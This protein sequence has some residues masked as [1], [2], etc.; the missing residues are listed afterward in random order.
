MLG[1]TD[2]FDQEECY[3][4]CTVAATRAQSLTIIISQFDM[5]GMMGMMQVL[6]AR[7]SELARNVTPATV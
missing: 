2:P 1:P 7:A 3:A 5:A 4:R 6:A